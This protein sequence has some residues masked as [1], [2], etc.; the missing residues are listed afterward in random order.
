MDSISSETSGFDSKLLVT[1]LW[2]ISLIAVGFISYFLGKGSSTPSTQKAP[3]PIAQDIL[4]TQVPV[5]PSPEVLTP[6]VTEDLEKKVC[7]KNGLSQ[8]KDYLVSYTIKPNDTIDNIA[9]EQLRDSSRV[10]EILTLNGNTQ[11]VVGGILYLP[12]AGIKQSSGN[13]KE[14]SGMITKNDASSWQ[15]SYGGGVKGLGLWIPGYWF[16]GIVGKDN[17]KI[18]DC[19]TILL[20]DGYKVYSIKNSAN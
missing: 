16:N 4:P 2:I 1:F 20:D 6:A 3:T 5:T 9:K 7:P 13:V 18:G 15:L 11:L 17:Y 12:P 10:N 14:V 8:K 19:V